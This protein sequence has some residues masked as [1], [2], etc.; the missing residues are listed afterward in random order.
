MS[1]ISVL[2]VH[3]YY[4]K[5]KMRPPYVLTRKNLL[6]LF[7]FCVLLRFIRSYYKHFPGHVDMLKSS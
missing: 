2:L 5:L 6:I 4:K 7:L 1:H 3:I